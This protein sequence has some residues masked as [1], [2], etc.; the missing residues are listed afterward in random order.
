MKILYIHQYFK[1]YAE[2]G[3]SRSYYLAKALVEQGHQVVMITSHNKPGYKKVNVEGIIVH[4]LPVFYD[5]TLG[6]TGRIFSFLRFVLQACRL[7]LSIKN[8]QLCYATSTPL[9]I[10]VIALV[11]KKLRGIPYYFE[12]RDLW[13]QAP[14][15]MGVIRNG[16]IKKALYGLEKLIYRQARKIIALSPG[17]AHDIA[18]K[19]A[20]SRKIYVIPNMAD[21]EFF[22][23]EDI[24]QP[25]Q[26]QAAGQAVF[27]ISYFG[28]VGKVNKLSYLVETARFFQEKQL[29]NIRFQVIGKG[30]EYNHIQNLAHSYQLTNINFLPHTDK[31][32]LREKLATTDAVYISF[33]QKPVMET[34]SPNKF[35]DA[36]A[37]GKL[38]IVNTEGWV[39]EAIEEAGC[40]FYADPEQPEVFYRKLLPYLASKRKL[41]EAKAAS[42]HLAETQFSRKLLT[43]LFLSLFPGSKPVPVL[44][45]EAVSDL[46]K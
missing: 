40:G 30:S 44:L 25:P 4:Y 1:T 35:F 34:S 24:F 33:A 16:L 31:Y 3:S 42:R 43:K 38:C 17:M 26:K 5:N 8:I 37:A 29:T 11:L 46:E 22:N 39:R 28:A 19:I 7:A 13:P 9:T 32:Q 36:L 41:K 27:S 18:E 20:D 2:G 12:V 45:G 6:F 21:C 23:G 14:I 10:G 15:E